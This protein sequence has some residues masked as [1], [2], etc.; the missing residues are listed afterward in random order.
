MAASL[1]SRSP[2]AFSLPPLRR[3]V[4]GTRLVCSE[5]KWLLLAPSVLRLEDS[6]ATAAC[7]DV[8]IGF[9]SV[10]I[11]TV[12]N[13]S[14]STPEADVGADIVLR[15]LVPLPDSCSAANRSLFD[16]LDSA[17]VQIGLRVPMNHQRRHLA[18]LQPGV[19]CHCRKS[20]DRETGARGLRSTDLRTSRR[21]P[22]GGKR[23][24]CRPKRNSEAQCIPAAVSCIILSASSRVKVLGF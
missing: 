6:P 13:I 4:P 1:R 9:T 24:A 19:G 15:R 3:Q 12:C 10:E 7:A 14:A 8:R 2:T 22:R 18:R 17:A 11:R 20:S 23:N 5:S 16:H 21:P